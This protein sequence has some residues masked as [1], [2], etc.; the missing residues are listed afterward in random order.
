MMEPPPIAS[1]FRMD[2][3]IFARQAMIGCPTAVPNDD[4]LFLSA[5]IMKGT[6]LLSSGVFPGRE[7]YSVV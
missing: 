2:M 7:L 6:I 4:S 1:E 3:G 5:Y